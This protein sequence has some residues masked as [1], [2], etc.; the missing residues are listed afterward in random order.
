MVRYRVGARASS[1]ISA[2]LLM[3]MGIV[4]PI[5]VFV[6][7]GFNE[8]FGLALFF[9]VAFIV[10]AIMLGVEIVYQKRRDLALKGKLST[11]LVKEVE[12]IWRGRSGRVYNLIIS[13]HNDMGEKL[14][15]CIPISYWDKDKY[16]VGVAINVYINGNYC[17][18]QKY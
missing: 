13:C 7:V 8:L 14:E 1:V 2:I 15:T 3:T 17:Y 9:F 12:R 6:S 16:T 10:G 11:G 4:M 18:I 5:V